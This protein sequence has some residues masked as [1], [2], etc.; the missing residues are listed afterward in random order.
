MNKFF[1]IK[2]SIILIIITFLS[3][4]IAT[5]IENTNSKKSAW[6]LVYSSFFFE[7]L[8]Y[9]IIVFLLF[10]IINFKMYRKEK[11]SIFVFHMSFILIII[12]A[13]ITKNHG[14]K[15]KIFIK[16]N[17]DS[18]S[19][20][21]QDMYL[22]IKELKNGKSTTIISKG[23]E[24]LNKTHT[25]NN[26]FIKLNDKYY[27]KNGQTN[28]ILDLE[29]GSGVMAFEI[30]NKDKRDSYLFEGKDFLKFN[31]LDIL[32]NIPSKDKTKPYFKIDAH[33]DKRI[34]FYSNIDVST[35]YGEKLEKNIFHELH[36]GIIYYINEKK[37]LISNIMTLAKTKFE[38]VNY[39]AS[40]FVIDVSYNG[41][42][43]EL[44]LLENN[45]SLDNFSN[46][47]YFDKSRFDISFQREVTRLPFK[48]KLYDYKLKN[49]AGSSNIYTYESDIELK[50]KDGFSIRKKIRIND[51]LTYGFFTIFQTKYEKHGSTILEINYNPGKY[52]IY[53]GYFLLT[54]G[55]MLTLINPNSRFRKLLSQ[56]N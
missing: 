18:N 47:I 23:L 16:V 41:K 38:P 21:S 53:I 36:Q 56:T 35:N 2:N 45:N 5:Y 7:L 8:F 6:E 39:G 50:D 4:T 37:L 25:I 29:N 44:A 52:I 31:N 14:Y 51:P 33:T 30:L 3:M 1:S 17:Q 27:I 24:S 42:T 9:L 34:Q 55:L 20:V 12:G 19:L 48:I 26:K 40:A 46:N 15:G 13:L 49:Y 43:R 22:K 28:I 32:F 10:N 11:F 54:L